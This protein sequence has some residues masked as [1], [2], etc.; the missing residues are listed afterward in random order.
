MQHD[1]PD[2]KH[3]G[4]GL[5]FLKYIPDRFGAGRRALGASLENPDSR[6]LF[7][8]VDRVYVLPD[9]IARFAKEAVA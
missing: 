4:L 9:H 3:V 7:T 5:V 2:S 8:K 6:S 1:Q